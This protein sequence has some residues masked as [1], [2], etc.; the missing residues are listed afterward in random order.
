MTSPY[1]LFS[2]L[3]ACKHAAKQTNLNVVF[4]SL[5]NDR[6]SELSYESFY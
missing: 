5:D 4:R 1:S 3:V 6:K 2:F